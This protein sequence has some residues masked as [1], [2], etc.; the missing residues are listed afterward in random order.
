MNTIT[1]HILA[2][3]AKRVP[4]PRKRKAKPNAKSHATR[5]DWLLAAVAIVRPLFDDV[6]AGDYPPLR[7]S[8]G[9]PKGGRKAIGQCWPST[10]SGDKTVEVFLSPELDD[11]ELILATLIHE[12]IHAIDNCASGHK[13]AFRKMWKALGFVGKATQSEPGED[14]LEAI[15]GFLRKLGPYPHS[16]LDASR[17]TKQGT[18]MV[19]LECECGY[20]VRTT[21]K[22]IEVGLPVCCCGYE[23][24]ESE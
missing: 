10:R 19:K 9:W 14:L 20:T 18:R 4:A 3:K 2:A 17:L 21:R 8:C 1:D 5:E 12:L 13:G 22:W 24:E 6:N 7:V 11:T 15:K 23:M 16:A